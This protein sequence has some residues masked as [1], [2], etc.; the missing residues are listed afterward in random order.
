MPVS[1]H[2]R[3]PR[4]GIDPVR[5]AADAMAVFGTQ[6]TRPLAAETLVMFLGDD[7]RGTQL[8][9][10]GGTD[11]REQLVEIV[12]V[13][14]Q[15]AGRVPEI[16]GLVLATVRPGGEMVAADTDL[17]LEA[18]D[19]AEQC[20][21]ELIDWLLVTRHGVVSPR[22]QLGMPSRWQYGP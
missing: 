10:V 22:E 9:T 13:M 17:W 18:A 2:R 15:A 21:I 12:E 5:S 1:S 8:I 19:M 6:I 4:G 14:A 20:G 11:R 16:A 3:P 7:R